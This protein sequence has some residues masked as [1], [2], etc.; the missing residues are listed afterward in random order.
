MNKTFPS[1]TV[2]CHDN[3]THFQENNANHNRNNFLTKY[4][5]PSYYPNASK[6]AVL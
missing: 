5:K 6:L 4:K 2:S 3:K 1:N